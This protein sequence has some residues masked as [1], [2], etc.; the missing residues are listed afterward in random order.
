MRPE[1]WIHART[2]V[3]SDLV[4]PLEGTSQRPSLG[5]AKRAVD[6]HPYGYIRRQRV[7][8][9]LVR[10]EATLQAGWVEE[11]G[12]AGGAPDPTALAT[13]ETQPRSARPCR[14][15]AGGHAGRRGPRSLRL[16]GQRHRPAPA[17]RVAEG[18]PGH[19][20]GGSS[21]ARSARIRGTSRA[22][23]RGRVGG[24]QR[25]GTFACAPC[26]AWELIRG[27]L[28]RCSRARRQT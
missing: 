23:R 7:A 22:C 3:G 18:G 25:D 26:A 19:S 1:V 5:V 6:D 16:G 12:E 13:A 11:Q 27:H 21:A 2:D 24:R 4:T 9:R 15:A 10:Q 17:H 8:F 14:R 20:A 28:A